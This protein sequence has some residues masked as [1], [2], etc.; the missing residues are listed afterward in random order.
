MT[1]INFIVNT[2]GTAKGFIPWLY[3]NEK[4]YILDFFYEKEEGNKYI[5]DYV[6]IANSYRVDLE[7]STGS[8]NIDGRIRQVF[9]LK[10]KNFLNSKVF[11]VKEK[12]V[13][14]YKKFIK[15]VNE[16]K[17]WP[18]VCKEMGYKSRGIFYY[19]LKYFKEHKKDFEPYI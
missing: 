10:K 16:G 17:R 19:K 11:K 1:D 6:K 2:S 18:E 3:S 14:E 7:I 8:L 12:K 13:K 4:Y 5:T 15:L 9:V